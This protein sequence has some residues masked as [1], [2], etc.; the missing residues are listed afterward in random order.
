MRFSKIYILLLAFLVLYCINRIIYRK[1]LE[2]KRE[3]IQEQRQRL[4]QFTCQLHQ[5]ETNV[6]GD[7]KVLKEN[8]LFDLKRKVGYCPISKT[9]S[10][11]WMRVFMKWSGIDKHVGG[12][13]HLRMKELYRVSKITYKGQHLQEG[14]KCSKCPNFTLIPRVTLAKLS[15]PSTGE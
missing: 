15:V 14:K 8:F 2:I 6:S 3:Q 9:G 5:N 1:L 4:I 11:T 12:W 10:S 13:G 7:T